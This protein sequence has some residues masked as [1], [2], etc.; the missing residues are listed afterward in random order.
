[1]I[2]ILIIS[3]TRMGDL[4]QASPL[5]AAL[6]K[7]HSAV[8]LDVLVSSDFVQV[9]K[10]IPNIDGV[11]IFNLKQFT[12]L[13]NTTGVEK[14]QDKAYSKEPAS[15]EYK[16]EVDLVIIYRYVEGIIDDLQ[17]SNYDMVINLSH[18]K[19]SAIITSL[20]NVQ[21]IRGIT[22]SGFGH[23]MIKHPWL[24][25]FAT[26]LFNRAYNSFNLVDVYLKTGDVKSTEE[27]LLLKVDKES[28]K[29]S[30]E[31][32][33]KNGV[34]KNDF[35]V[36][37]QPGANLMERRWPAK[38]FAN[39]GNRIINDLNGK[40]VLF[41]VESEA[42]LGLEIE[43]MI[44]GKIINTIGKTSIQ[45]LTALVKKCST[46]V[47]NDTG[48][49]HIATAMG[50]RVVGLFFAHAFPIE[51]GPYSS[52]NIVFQ[53]NI[54]CSPCSY[55]VKCNNVVCVNHVK[56]D[57]LFQVLKLIKNGEVDNTFFENNVGMEKIKIFRSTFDQDHILE[58]L[59]I[60]KRPLT[61]QEFF[62]FVYRM[63]WKI[64][65]D[66]TS[67]TLEEN[68]LDKKEEKNIIIKLNTYYNLDEFPKIYSQITA[69]MNEFNKLWEIT[70]QASRLTE[71]LIKATSSNS[72][73]LNKI[74]S[75]GEK[76]AKLDEKIHLMA[77]TN[78]TIKPIIDI[79]LLG[80]ENLQGDIIA[81]LAKETLS[82]YKDMK[83]QAGFIYRTGSQ[84]CESIV[85]LKKTNLK[86]IK[87]T[88]KK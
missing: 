36:G 29:F 33:L 7:K 59:P 31:L 52:G 48:T 11:K 25:Y 13:K 21:D 87:G 4:L 39:L 9:A 63:M 84:L 77:L 56:S 83:H 47:S 82:L 46:L 51:T 74:Q 75:F 28:I 24:R 23:R 1:M 42:E 67:K 65:L 73:D 58:F 40:V 38:S 16:K 60:I 26:I 37:F 17:K 22:S 3:L 44:K 27:H 78:P 72:Q 62:R 45:Q 41:G 88:S 80:K 49:M 43:K 55:G 19:L 20:I 34:S 85:D 30:D 76:I 70:K 79:F 81:I 71:K 5:I 57:H 6:K 14:G 68:F 2:K 66:Q 69:T 54:P 53:A 18:S 61:K 12:P 86:Y 64:T 50:T 10:S 15:S 8:T 35:L 32:L